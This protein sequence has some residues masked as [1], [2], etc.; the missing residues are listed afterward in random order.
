MRR[1]V[2]T[3]ATLAVVALMPGCNRKMK[4]SH[5]P[6]PDTRRDTTVVDDYH[7]TRVADP[8]RWLED[9]NS[10]E[11][12]AWVEAENA[13]TRDYL[14]RLPARQ[15]I[16]DRLTALYDYP[17]EGAPER[18]G[19]YYYYFL[20]DGLQN[21]SALW[22]KRSLT[23]QGELFLDPN[24]LSADGTTALV[25]VSFS[26]DG[27]WCA[28]AAAEAGSDWVRIHVVD[29]ATGQLTQDVIE[30]VKFSGATWAPDSEGFY[31]SAYDAPK[32]NVYSSKNECQKVY[33]HR[34]GTA[35]ADDILIY[36]DPEHP[37]RY[38]SGWESD[39]GRWLFVLA[40]EGTSGSE[41]LFRPADKEEPFRTLLAGFANDY[42]PVECRDDKLYV[43]TNDSA[44]NYRLAR[45]DLLEPRG[46][47][48][49]I[50]EHPD[51]LLEAVAPGGGYLWVKYL[52]N[53]QNKIYKYDYEGN[54]QAD[55]PLPAI[56][57]VPSFGC[58]DREQEIFFSLNTFTAPPT[59]YR[60]DIP[61]GR[62][63]CYHTPQVAYDAAQY[64]TEQ[65]F[66][67]S[68][69]GEHVPMFVSHRR[70]L[71]LDGSNPCYL[72]GYGGFQINI[73]PAFKPEHILFMEQ[74]RGGERQPARRFGIRRAVAQGWYARPQ[75]A[76]LRRFH[77]GGRIPHHREVYLARKAGHR[78]RLERRIAGGRLRSAAPRPVRRLPACGRRDGHVA[79]PPFHHRLGLGDRIRYERRC[80]A[81]PH[82]LRLLA[83]AQH[84]RRR[85]LPRDA[86]HDGRPR[87][88]CGAG[89]FVQIR[90]DAP[91]C[92]GVRCSG[93]DP[94]RT[95]CRPRRGQTALE[96]YRRIGRQLRF[97][98]LQYGDDVRTIGA[99]ELKVGEGRL[100]AP[101]R[102]VPERVSNRG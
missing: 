74:R 94:H 27:R 57:S 42:A 81:V 62:T 63:T 31:Y 98:V 65:L 76:G 83:A 4:I 5:L 45:I 82:A 91:I 35:Q 101:V 47:E 96:A 79:L 86:R 58:K 51:D 102:A 72:Y 34:L 32:A 38:F 14:D 43:V 80:G 24:T 60:Y 56:G 3:A 30:W 8:Y 54:R 71:R 11:T 52:R 50:A 59:V 85:L 7:G 73:T 75:A 49:V 46:L 29:T 23:A 97:P 44:A 13:V 67:E 92:A 12:A 1:F 55:V 77:R 16:Y 9:D 36:G 21:Q 53:A 78:R 19:D 28:Y 15:A 69:D 18:H 95:E 93:A 10:A 61:T 2:W 33:Y 48:T 25:D 39:D 26:D 64:T 99:G 88:S 90:C 100:T 37:L 41:V 70:G 89:A 17:K 84:P 87:R 40:S 66:F 6:Y 68:S 20:N 22:R